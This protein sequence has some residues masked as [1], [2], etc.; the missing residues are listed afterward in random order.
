MNVERSAKL[1]LLIFHP[2]VFRDARGMFRELYNARA[3]EAAGLDA[4]FVQDNVSRSTRHTLRGLHLQHPNDQGKLV[5]VLE[6]AVFDVAVDVRVD[7]PQLG[8][9][10]SF[11]LSDENAQQVYLPPGYAHGFVVLSETA[12]FAYK[13]TAAYS[14]ADEITIRWDDPSIGIDWPTDRPLLSGR[15][16][17]A[18]MLRELSHSRLPVVR[19]HAP[20]YAASAT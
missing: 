19:S 15:D 16:A 11:V 2:Q 1:G 20:R 6:G 14:P 3:Y 13:C 5:T 4:D 12:L 17:A 7:S 10:E 8:Q 18:P 9:W